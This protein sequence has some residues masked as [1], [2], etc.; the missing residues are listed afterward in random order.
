MDL[1]QLRDLPL[2]FAFGIACLWFY[3]Q[4]NV[5]F[6]K[7]Y[8]A[9]IE[10]FGKEYKALVDKYDNLV[11]AIAEEKRQLVSDYRVERSD[12]L[13]IIKANTEAMAKAATEDHALRNTL[14]PLIPRLSA[15]SRGNPDER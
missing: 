11:D 13:T 2:A 14:A 12:L 6:G 15:R 1:L 9:L 10:A 4:S 8:V 5:E 7:K 3:N